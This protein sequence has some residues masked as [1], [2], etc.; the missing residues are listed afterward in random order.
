[1]PKLSPIAYQRLVKIFE[2]DGFQYDRTE[3]DHMMFKKHGMIRPV[4]IPKYSSVP[5][6][7]IK[8]NLR[9][10]GISR[11]RYFELLRER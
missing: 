4:V 9:I 11:D 3:G 7:I 2:A 8:N 10:A 1:M 6:F 5:V